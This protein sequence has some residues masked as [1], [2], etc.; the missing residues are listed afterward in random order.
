M[1]KFLKKVFRFNEP[2]EGLI[3]FRPDDVKWGD[4]IGGK[5]VYEPEQA[6]PKEVAD[7]EQKMK[8]TTFALLGVNEASD[9]HH[10]EL[11]KIPEDE[12]IPDWLNIPNFL[13]GKK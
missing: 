12:E 10:V 7:L 4:W 8:A 13:R 3:Q 2:E 6:T 9:K 1:I 5:P 11:H